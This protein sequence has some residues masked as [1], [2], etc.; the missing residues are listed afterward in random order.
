MTDVMQS[1]VQTILSNRHP[2][3]FNMQDVPALARDPHALNASFLLKRVAINPNSVRSEHRFVDLMI[4]N[5]FWLDRFLSKEGVF[6]P[7]ADDYYMHSPELNNSL[8]GYVIYKKP[9]RYIKSVIEHCDFPLNEL[10]RKTS[11]S[12][13]MIELIGKAPSQI[14]ANLINQLFMKTN[15]VVEGVC[16]YPDDILQLVGHCNVDELLSNIDLPGIKAVMHSMVSRHGVDL[17]AESFFQC[18][19]PYIQADYKHRLAVLLMNQNFDIQVSNTKQIYLQL[20]APVLHYL[21]SILES[22]LEAMRQVM[23]LKIGAPVEQNLSLL[24]NAIILLNNAC[25]IFDAP[26]N[27]TEL[28]DY[29]SLVS[30]LALEMTSKG[31]QPELVYQLR[32]DPAALY[33]VAVVLHQRTKEEFELLVEHINFDDLTRR[34][35]Q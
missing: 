33:A 30:S 23:D 4:F 27:S 13:S 10:S 25:A 31:E 8:I 7:H 3:L 6:S 16:Q 5:D 2:L 14:Q 28:H 19:I 9:N 35:I 21:K 24:N 32:Q 26:V 1:L 34:D 29:A 15:V 17:H 12:T 11:A 22:K 20:P 18:I